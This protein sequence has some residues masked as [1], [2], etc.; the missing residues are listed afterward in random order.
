MLLHVCLELLEELF[1]GLDP[2]H[3]PA[4]CVPELHHHLQTCT[5]QS[6]C[7]ISCM[8]HGSYVTVT[9]WRVE[10]ALGPIW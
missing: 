8:P 5:H 10:G 7:A 4:V 9:D 3:M 6:A 1:Q 2:I